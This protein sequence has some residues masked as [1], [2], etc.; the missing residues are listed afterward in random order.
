MEAVKA[1]VKNYGTS[2]TSVRK[3]LLKDVCS[4]A[5]IGGKATDSRRSLP[6]RG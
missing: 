6:S 2:K 4:E 5:A 1:F 3:K